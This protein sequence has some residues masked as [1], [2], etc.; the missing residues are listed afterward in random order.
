[1]SGDVG[2]SATALQVSSGR[3][4]SREKK[5]ADAARVTEGCSASAC[6]SM[7]TV[8]DDEDDVALGIAAIA[9]STLDAASTA[10][11][12]RSLP[13]AS[14][15]IQTSNATTTR[16]K[17]LFG[18]NRDP[19]GAALCAA[20][21]AAPLRRARNATSCCASPSPTLCPALPT[22]QTCT[23]RALQCK[24]S[25]VR[26]NHTSRHCTC[27]PAAPARAPTGRTRPPR[28]T[29][30]SATTTHS[31]RSPT[32]PTSVPHKMTHCCRRPAAAAAAGSSW[33]SSG[34]AC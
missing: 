23:T 10:A 12:M 21:S 32:S 29:C 15:T 2:T 8:G 11:A 30:T 5:A 16:K 17:R 33:T 22:R 1:M 4:R 14:T 20:P 31:T 6:A 27:A 18:N 7:T 34:R 25:S 26:T 3:V 28:S 13:H 24:H 9:P 19:N